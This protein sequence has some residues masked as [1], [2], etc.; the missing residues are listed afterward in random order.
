[1]MNAFNTN[2]DENSEHKNL[3]IDYAKTIQKSV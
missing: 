3:T 2:Y 1:M